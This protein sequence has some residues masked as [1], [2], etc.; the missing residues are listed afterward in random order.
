MHR[1][2]ALSLVLTGV[3]ATLAAGMAA[4]LISRRQVPKAILSEAEALALYSSPGAAPV[5]P[6]SVFHLGHSLV[7]RDIPVMVAQ[8]AGQGHVF[9]SQLGWGASLKNHWGPVDD[10][11]GF[12]SENSHSNARLATQAIDSGLYDAVVFTEMVDIRDAIRYHE[13]AK[14]LFR[15]AARARKANPNVA[16]YFYE[17]W[18]NTNDAEGWLERVDKDLPRHWEREILLPAVRADGRP[19]YVIPGGQ[20]LSAMV[21][22]I[23]ARGGIDGV[24]RVEDFFA[25][26]ADGTQDTI[27]LNDLGAYVIAVTHYAVLYQSNPIGLPNA[28]LRADGSAAKAPGQELANIIQQT[29]WDIVTAYDKTGVSA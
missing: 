22:A 24:T 4:T 14:Y 5:A 8:L 16:I 28:L 12:V 23:I 3:V 26:A 1:R 10:I 25:L 29:V 6:R 17:T 20:A 7:G 21:R 11:S 9:H 27:H 19:I 15:W 18:P 2:S 13:S